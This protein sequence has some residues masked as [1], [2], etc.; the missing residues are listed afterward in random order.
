MGEMARAEAR[1]RERDDGPDF[2]SFFEGEYERL[3][4]LAHVLC[5]NRTEAEDLAQEAMVRVYERWDRVR[6][7][8][9]PAAY[10]YRVAVNLR[11]SSWRR[12]AVA[13][14]HRV[15]PPVQEEPDVV[16]LRRQE[17]LTALRSPPLAQRE[18]LLLVEWMGMSSE[19]AGRV[20][21]IAPGS[22]RGRVHRARLALR[23]RAGGVDDA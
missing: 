5:R 22:V 1:A 2:G 9:S 8:D 15:P 7:A 16:A 14:R 3:L 10:L 11:R 6:E 21:G 20:L 18:A 23:E 13:L 4:K 12:A 17:I 19:E